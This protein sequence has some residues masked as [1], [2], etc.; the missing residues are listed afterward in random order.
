MGLHI[1][2]MIFLGVSRYFLL[3]EIIN[4]FKWSFTPML[5]KFSFRLILFSERQAGYEIL[6]TF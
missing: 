2:P 3:C 5:S 1:S 6:S 4:K